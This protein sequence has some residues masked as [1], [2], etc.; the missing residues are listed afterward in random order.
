M[1]P[2]RR[3]AAV[4]A[5]DGSMRT[6]WLAT[7]ERGQGGRERETIPAAHSHCGYLSPTGGSGTCMPSIFLQLVTFSGLRVSGG[8]SHLIGG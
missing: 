4:G 7:S 6:I 8:A 2:G 5:A 1:W 3:A